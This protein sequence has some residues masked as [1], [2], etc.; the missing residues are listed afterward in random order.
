MSR[1]LIAAVFLAIA[2]AGSSSNASAISVTLD[3]YSL[4]VVR[5]LSGSTAADFTG[6]VTISAG[7]ELSLIGASSLWTA[8]GDVINNGVPSFSFNLDGTLFSVPVSATDGLGLYAFDITRVNPAWISYIECTIGGGA[9]NNFMF[10]Y[11]V[12][13]IQAPVPEPASIVLLALGLAGLGLYR[14]RYQG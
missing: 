3:D 1:K 13:V 10:N 2:A 7:Y 4:T 14:R 11:S 8:S 6:H 12:N 9:C 5:P